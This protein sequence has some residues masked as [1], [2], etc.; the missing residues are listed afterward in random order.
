MTAALELGREPHLHDIAQQAVPQQASAEHENIRVVVQSRHPCG[1]HVVDQRG[2][3]AREL[4]RR[5]RHPDS[6]PAQ[7]NAP[8]RA[9]LGHGPCDRLSIVRIV[10]R[11]IVVS[12][13]VLA[14]QAQPGNRVQYDRLGSECRMVRSDYNRKIFG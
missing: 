13:E 8:R 14:P 9:P 3:H 1:R 5:D 4:V 11:A 10:D 12:T 7:Q 6:R 2:A